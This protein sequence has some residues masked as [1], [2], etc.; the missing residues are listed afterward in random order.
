MGPMSLLVMFNCL[1]QSQIL[2]GYSLAFFVNFKINCERFP[3][4][5]LQTVSHDAMGTL[6]ANG[7]LLKTFITLD[8]VVG[9][10]V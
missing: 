3:A 10:V 2:A 8:F 1:Q 9:S 4:A 5:S 7:W 6:S